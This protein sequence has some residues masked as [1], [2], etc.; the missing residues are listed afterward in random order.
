MHFRRLFPQII[1]FA[2]VFYGLLF[3]PTTISS[4]EPSGNHHS[5]QSISL[6]RHLNPVKHVNYD[7]SSPLFDMTGCNRPGPGIRTV[8]PQDALIALGR[9]A[10]APD[11]FAIRTFRS[12]GSLAT[13]NTA[14]IFLAK[15]DAGPDDFSIFDI[16]SQALEVIKYCIVHQP[17]AARL[18]GALEVGG[19]N[20]FRLVVQATIPH[21]QDI[22]E[23]R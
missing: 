16:A 11:F 13:W 1:A 6:S 22:A 14:A 2:L 20:R 15:I 9:L 10:S 19:Q 5:A 4:P 12:F 17:P 3:P 8:S 7:T 23:T 18:G 21:E